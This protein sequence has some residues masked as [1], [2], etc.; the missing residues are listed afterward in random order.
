MEFDNRHHCHLLIIT[1]QMLTETNTH[2]Q[3]HTNIPLSRL[4]SI[5]NSY[6][7]DF[8]HRLSEINIL[9]VRY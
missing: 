3:I 6:L 2:T 5:P 8:Q 9:E 4:F 7:Y 1:V